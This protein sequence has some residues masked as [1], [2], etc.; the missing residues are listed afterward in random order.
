MIRFDQWG[1][2]DH[3][4]EVWVEKDAL[5]SVI[6][7]AC[8]PL[9]V[10]HMACKGY[11][12]ASE[13]WRAG[14]RFEHAFSLGKTCTLIHLGDHDPSGIDMTRDNDDRI[15]M[16]SYGSPV[17]V[18]RIALNMDQIAEYAPPPN[19]TKLSDSRAKEY[20]KRYGRESWELD[21]LEPKV[22]EKL[23]TDTVSPLI[24]WDIWNDTASA[25]GEVRNKLKTLVNVWDDMQDQ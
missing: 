16:L 20:I 6:E 2:Q 12:S 7:K 24:D 1:R 14:K 15:E 8:Q 13:A 5:G 3:Y 21:A 11:L 19:P 22:L 25:Q 18:K 10:P 4:V 23:I 17:E 9:M